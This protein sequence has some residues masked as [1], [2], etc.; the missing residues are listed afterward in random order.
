MNRDTTLAAACGLYCGDCEFLEKQCSG[1][2]RLGGKPFWTEQYGVEVCP[3]YVCCVDQKE[4][5]HCGLCNEFPCETFTSLRDPSMTDAQFERSLEERRADLNSRR[6][7]GTEAWLE[8]KN[9]QGNGD[10]EARRR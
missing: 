3:I 4:L 7:L 1:C 6:E 9:S 2:T 8:R 10:A 5:E